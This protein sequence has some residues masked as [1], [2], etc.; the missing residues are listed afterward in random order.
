MKEFVKRKAM[1]EELI[2]K[3]KGGY[4]DLSTGWEDL[5]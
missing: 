2:K 4:W 3:K 1:E 5:I